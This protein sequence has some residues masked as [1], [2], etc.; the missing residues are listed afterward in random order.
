MPKKRENEAKK[1]PNTPTK[2]TL[3]EILNKTKAT[4]KT[5]SKVV[6]PY[7]TKKAVTSNTSKLA[8]NNKKQV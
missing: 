2:Y 3:G 6:S 5:S 1:V 8:Q 7:E 4:L